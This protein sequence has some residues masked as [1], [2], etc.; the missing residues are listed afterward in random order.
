M[1]KNKPVARIFFSPDPEDFQD[2]IFSYEC[3]LDCGIYDVTYV[4]LVMPLYGEPTDIF[5]D[6]SVAI[7]NDLGLK[8]ER[9]VWVKCEIQKV[10]KYYKEIAA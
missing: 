8:D 7:A 3:R 10:S 5:Q 6:L 4:E 9:Y 1:A 2:V